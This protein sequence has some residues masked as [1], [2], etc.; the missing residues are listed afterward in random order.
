MNRKIENLE[1]FKEYIEQSKNIAIFTHLIPDGDAIG[2][3]FGLAKLLKKLGKK[4]KVYLPS[5]LPEEYKYFNILDYLSCD[6]PLNNN[7]DLLI[8]TDCGAYDRL[9]DYSKYFLSHS[10]TIVIDHH[11]S[12]EPFAK[13]NLL[14]VESSSASEFVYDLICQCN[15]EIDK[16]IAEL[17]YLGILRDSGGFM[18]SCTTPHTL[19]AVAN[20]LEYKID[21]EN[22]NRYFMMRSSYE[23]TMLLKVVLNNLKLF[24]NNEVVIS[25]ISMDELCMNK[26]TIE[27]TGG[28]IAQILSIDKVQVAVLITETTK[29]VHKVSIR[30]KFE[31]DAS[32]IALEFGGGGHKKASGFQITGKID[33]IITKIIKSIEKRLV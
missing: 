27:D 31:V 20:L 19:R 21:Y 5:N 1:K 24:L 16:E 3:A 22:I 29:N 2:S 26:A 13:L 10:K 4:V 30:S 25:H 33:N 32:Q 11:I 17:L 28:I 15:Y 12:F 8:A 6:N 7:F 23:K 18:Y 9:G 14:S